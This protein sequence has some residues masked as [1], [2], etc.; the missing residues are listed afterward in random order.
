MAGSEKNG[1]DGVNPALFNGATWVLTPGPQTDPEAYLKVRNVVTSLG[2]EVVTLDADEHDEMVATISHVPHLVASA[3]MTEAMQR[4]HSHEAVLR[5]AAGGFRDMTRIA[6]GHAEL[7]AD[8]ALQNRDAIIEGLARLTTTLDEVSEMLAATRREELQSWLLSAA[9]A[10]RELPSRQGRP[11]QLVSVSVVIPD[12]P[13][14]LG[15]V[16]AVF[17][18][19][20]INVEDV[21]INHAVEGGR[22]T[23]MLTIAAVH[24]SKAG[25]ALEEAGLIATL[26][27]L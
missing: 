19:A 12:R 18:D 27:D 3:I 20:R 21:E 13:G 10:R 16:F 17:G 8:I 5:L 23:L 24:A 1:L 26:E 9:D 15:H 11:D 2:A 22:G 4:A 25:A 14:A 7:W 6:A